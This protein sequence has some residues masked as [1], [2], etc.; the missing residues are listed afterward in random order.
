MRDQSG[1][2]ERGMG[3]TRERSTDIPAFPEELEKI[4]SS[5][6]TTGG[7]SPDTIKDLDTGAHKDP[8]HSP[9]DIDRYRQA[10]PCHAKVTSIMTISG[11]PPISLNLCAVKQKACACVPGWSRHGIARQRAAEHGETQ[12]DATRS[13]ETEGVEGG[14]KGL[15]T[16]P[17]RLVVKKKPTR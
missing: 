16:T 4:H 15:E 6:K 9:Q 10:M 11:N 14:G 8:L 2:S 12:Q 5:R 7:S 17:R 1:A 3:Q 13:K